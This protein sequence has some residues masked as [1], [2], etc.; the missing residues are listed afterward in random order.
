M[1][2]FHFSAMDFDFPDS[3]VTMRSFSDEKKAGTLNYFNKKTVESWQ[4]VNG[5]ILVQYY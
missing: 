1:T 5:K 2:L 4:I 3:A